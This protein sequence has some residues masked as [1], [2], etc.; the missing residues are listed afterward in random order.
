MTAP[1]TASVSGERFMAR[2]LLEGWALSDFGGT[3]MEEPDTNVL[4]ELDTMV[5]ATLAAGIIGALP[6]LVHKDGGNTAR[7]AAKLYFDC[8]EAI[9]LERT[10]RRLKAGEAT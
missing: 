3:A 6:D 9:Q 2:N 1:A 4:P 5:A 8:L 10:E 7:G